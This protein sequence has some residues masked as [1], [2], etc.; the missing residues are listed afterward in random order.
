MTHRSRQAHAGRFGSRKST[1]FQT[2]TWVAL[3]LVLMFAGLMSA[4][5]VTS[6]IQGRIYDTSGAAIPEASVT[7]VNSATGVSRQVTGSAAGDYQITLLPQAITPSQRRRVA[8]QNLLRK[9]TW[10]WE[11]S[12]VWTS[13][14]PSDK[15]RRKSWC[16]T[17]VKSPSPRGRWS[18]R[19]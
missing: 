14:L 13:I 9:C 12:A 6:S 8:S 1:L 16:R 19:S 11:R 15:S 17:S 2:R 5:T 7:A 3:A 4:Q 10:I 18:A